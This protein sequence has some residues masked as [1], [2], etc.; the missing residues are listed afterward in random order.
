MLQWLMPSGD[1]NI[2]PL[3]KNEA[4]GIHGLGRITG[5]SSIT[6]NDALEILKYLAGLPSAIA[7]NNDSWNAALITGGSVPTIADALEILKKLANLPNM[8]DG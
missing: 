8:I 5:T 6:I 7:P 4:G 3:Y 1:V 2:T